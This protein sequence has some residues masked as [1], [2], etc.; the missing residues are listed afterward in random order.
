MSNNIKVCLRVR[1]FIDR[2]KGDDCAVAM[3]TKTKL[4]LTEDAEHEHEFSYDRCYW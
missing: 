4:V 1:P 2:E 3:P